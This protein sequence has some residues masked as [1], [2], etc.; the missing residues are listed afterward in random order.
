M[1]THHEVGV[2]V[3]WLG[4]RR[5]LDAIVDSLHPGESLELAQTGSVHDP[6][7]VLQCWTRKEAYLKALGTG[8]RV[9]PDTFRV[10]A[11]PGDPPCVLEPAVDDTDHIWTVRDL[12]CGEDYSAV[13]VAEG[14]G[15]RCGA[16]RC[17]RIETQAL[18]NRV[19]T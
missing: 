5:A 19:L 7:A 2:D 15:F 9:A 18:P 4:R 3:E 10:S 16:S 6:R 12:D 11:R 17:R 13:V 1:S 14:A 8:L